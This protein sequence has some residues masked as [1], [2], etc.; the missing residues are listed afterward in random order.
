[1]GLGHENDWNHYQKLVLSKLD[2]HQIEIR[3]IREDT[4]RLR[5]DVSALKIRAGIWGALAGAI[6]AIAVA[7][8]W[9]LSQ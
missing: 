1:M 8:F 2:D 3:Y 5:V 4:A 7:L 9:L 6:P